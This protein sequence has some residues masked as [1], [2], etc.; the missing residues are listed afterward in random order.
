MS[1]AIELVEEGHTIRS[2]AEVT[3]VNYVTLSRRV[4]QKDQGVY[5]KPRCIFSEEE[6]EELRKY[7]MTCSRMSHGLT[8]E[9]TR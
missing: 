1:D 7:L 9:E 4:K 5:K 8:P 2:A 3:G 6:E